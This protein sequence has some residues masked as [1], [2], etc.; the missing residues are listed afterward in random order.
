MNLVS[1]PGVSRNSNEFIQRMDVAPQ[2]HINHVQF[3]CVSVPDA[4]HHAARIEYEH[5]E[6]L[7][8][9]RSFG[10]DE[11]RRRTTKDDE[12]QIHGLEKMRRSNVIMCEFQIA[13]ISLMLSIEISVVDIPIMRTRS[14]MHTGF[15]QDSRWLQK[16]GAFILCVFL[17]ET[18]HHHRCLDQLMCFASSRCQGIPRS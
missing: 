7:A 16:K 17:C 2:S 12:E 6:M 9:E 8:N 14:S 18:I 15:T 13:V 11:R 1:P 4:V 5:I 10:S 3:G